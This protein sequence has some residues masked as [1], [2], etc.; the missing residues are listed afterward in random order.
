MDLIGSISGWSRTGPVRRVQRVVVGGQ[1]LDPFVESVI[2]ARVCVKE[3]SSV[4]ESLCTLFWFHNFETKYPA[5]VMHESLLHCST[6]AKY[7]GAGQGDKPRGGSNVY[8]SR[9]MILPELTY[10]SLSQEIVSCWSHAPVRSK[11]RSRGHGRLASRLRL[12]RRG[13]PG[14]A[15]Q[16]VSRLKTLL[17]CRKRSTPPTQAG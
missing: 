16:A 3:S 12:G 10:C 17:L 13:N 15:S 5:D 11:D 4:Y 7:E 6:L 14:G 9:T 8:E 1:L 2:W